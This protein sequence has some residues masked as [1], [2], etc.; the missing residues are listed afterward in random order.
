MRKESEMME[1]IMKK[2]RE[3]D[4]IRA[5][6]M[7]GSRANKNAVHDQY[8]DFD[9][10]YFV[11]DV[12]EFTKDKSWVNYFGEILIVQCPMDW[13]SHP[14]DYSGNDAFTYLI[15]FADGNRID[16]SLV[17]IRNIE[18]ERKNNEPR[19]ILLNKD[20]F[21]ELR[22][23]E[24][25]DAFFIQ[26]PSKMEFYNTAN[27]FRWLSIYISKGL[28]REEFYYA[29]YSFDV[30]IMKMFMKMLNWTIGL[31]ND[32]KVTTGGY[33]KYLKRFLSEADMERVQGIFPDGRYENIWDKLFLMYDYFHELES[34]AAEYFH[35]AY[36]K[37]EE[38]GKR[39]REFLLKRKY[40]LLE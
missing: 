22:L 16:L 40:K 20:N 17:D 37:E 23:I 33:N 9:I 8:S 28:C 32:F 36:D 21:T 30:L 31:R 35:F 7:D 19:I 29:K 12:R 2:A 6:A 13:Y 18:K 10:V 26:P 34:E 27:E 3:D 14:Y 38:E 5:V 39:V 4:R 1:L 24:K 11:T 25:E 15:Q